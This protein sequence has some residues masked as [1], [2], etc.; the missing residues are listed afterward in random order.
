MATEAQRASDLLAGKFREFPGLVFDAEVSNISVEE[1]Y[2]STTGLKIEV[3]NSTVNVKLLKINEKQMRTGEKKNIR[4]LT[5]YLD[6]TTQPNM[7]VGTNTQFTIDGER[8]ICQE[9]EELPGGSVV[10]AVIRTQS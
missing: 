10:K 6:R 5:V 4:D 7:A 9:W 2:D 8:F 3:E 1:Q